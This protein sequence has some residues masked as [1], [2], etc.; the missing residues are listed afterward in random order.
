ML[1]TYYPIGYK[2]LWDNFYYS[3]LNLIVTVAIIY[4]S[5]KKKYILMIL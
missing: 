1:N 5:F 4:K 3:Y 2:T